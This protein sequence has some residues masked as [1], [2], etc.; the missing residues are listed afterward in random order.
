MRRSLWCSLL[1]YLIVLAGVESAFF[2]VQ[3]GVVLR[4]NGEFGREY[5]VR[6]EDKAAS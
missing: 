6:G 2:E 5:G 4:V 1:E 3:I